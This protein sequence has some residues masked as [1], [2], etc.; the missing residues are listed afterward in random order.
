MHIAAAD[1]EVGA[2]RG[3]AGRGD[4]EGEGDLPRADGEA[5]A[6]RRNVLDK[7]IEGKLG[8]FYSQFVLLDQPSIRD[9]SGDDRP[10][11]GAGERQDRREHPGQ[12]LRP[13]PRR[14]R[15]RIARRGRCRST[16]SSAAAV[17]HGKRPACGVSREPRT[18]MPTPAAAHRGGRYA[19]DVVPAATTI[20]PHAH[21]DSGSSP[22]VSSPGRRR[23]HASCSRS[24]PISCSA[25]WIG[26]LTG[27]DVAVVATR[28]AS[29]LAPSRT[30]GASTGAGPWRRIELVHDCDG[31]RRRR[32]RR[33]TMR[34]WRRCSARS[35]T[36]DVEQRLETVRLRSRAAHRRTRRCSWLS[37]A[38]TWS[39]RISSGARSA[40]EH[41][42]AA[43]AGLGGSLVRVRQA[44]AAR[45]RPGAR[46]GPI[47]RSGAADAEL[48]RRARATWARRWPKPNGRTRPSTRFNR[49]CDY[50]PA[51]YPD[52]Q[53]P[54]RDLS[55]A[56]ASRRGNR[57][58]GG[59]VD[60][61]RARTSSSA[62]TTSAHALFLQR[63][64]RRGA[65]RVRGGASRARSAEEHRCRHA[66]WRSREPRPANAI[67]RSTSST[68]S[69]DDT[70]R[71]KL[72]P[73][74]S[75]RRKRRS[76]RCLPLPQRTRSELD[77]ARCWA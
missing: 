34:R 61:S 72:G 57:R 3:R 65:R 16:A 71:R 75:A 9:G 63:A 25:G 62:T 10:A 76:T 33:G 8:S 7:I 69:R 73:R 70:A 39:S 18:A 14:R 42:L 27:R 21:L 32:S 24:R 12:P 46:G 15:R 53:Q 1:P 64:L 41:A 51:G 48:C 13:L 28:V 44:V 11:R 17:R 19:R 55:R 67:A 47:C 56:G 54:G 45:R 29:A 50:D 20:A 5:A 26:S 35:E 66:A 31:R 4:R 68:R 37:R 58:R 22:G 38:C 6:S 77:A 36:P 52:A 40:L 59:R 43:G 74:C 23:A 2:P 30:G 49:R 60:R